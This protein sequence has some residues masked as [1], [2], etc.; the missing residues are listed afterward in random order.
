MTVNMINCLM[1]NPWVL[2]QVI[3]YVVYKELIYVRNENYTAQLVVKIYQE[4]RITLQI[5][6]D[7]T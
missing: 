1:Y 3:L 7:N 2:A 6:P 4:V 5:T